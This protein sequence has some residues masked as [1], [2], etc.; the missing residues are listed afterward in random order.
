MGGKQKWCVQLLLSVLKWREHDLL[1]PSLHPRDWN[2]EAIDGT[3]AAILDPGSHFG[4]G[5]DSPE[6]LPTERPKHLGLT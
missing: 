4:P 3:L 6:L 1:C 2:S 5:D